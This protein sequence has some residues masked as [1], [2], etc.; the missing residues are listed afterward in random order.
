VAVAEFVSPLAVAIASSV[1]LDD[2]VIT[3]PLVHFVE[4]VV[5]GAIPVVP[6]V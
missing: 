1:S 6:R 5:V 4:L 3:V 2:T